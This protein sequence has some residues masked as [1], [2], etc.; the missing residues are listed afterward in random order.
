M[1]RVL[2]ADDHDLFRAG[3]K[4]LLAE[5]KTVAV[6]GEA[7]TGADAV[8]QAGTGDYDVILLDISMPGPSWLEVIAQIHAAKPSLPVL[9]LTMHP[10]EQ[11]AIRA[12][13]AGAAG[14]L[15]KSAAPDEVLAAIQRVALGRR[16]VS[17][18]LAEQLAT[19]LTE[20]RAAMPH[21]QLTD[22]EYQVMCLIASGNTIT[23]VAKELDLSVKT[24]ST[25]RSR[26][27]HKMGL[28]NNA[29]MIRYVL[30]HNLLSN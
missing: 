19:Y 27:L 17:A 20:G 22:R 23:Q 29:E 14:Y 1:I 13:R 24:I 3:L 16:F 6:T 5:G 15:T 4:G 7:S 30:E 8:A 18:S 25:Y 9:I 26:L 12:L 21:E 2:L 10:E 28:N 11:Y